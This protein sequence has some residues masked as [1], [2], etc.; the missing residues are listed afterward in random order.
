MRDW[1]WCGGGSRR[2]EGPAV[3]SHCMGD[4]SLNS[5]WM[6]LCG[7]E[8]DLEDEFEEHMAR[9]REAQC[10]CEHFEVGHPLGVWQVRSG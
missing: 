10:E 5:G 4:R 2:C 6:T 1:M 7:D 3:Q 8:Q 9:L